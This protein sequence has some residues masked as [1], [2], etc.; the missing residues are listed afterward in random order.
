MRIGRTA[1]DREHYDNLAE[2]YAVINSI[3]Y[4]EKAYI[5]DCVSSKESALPLCTLHF[6]NLEYRCRYTGACSKLLVQFKAS[7][8]L[9]KGSDYADVESFVQKFRVSCPAITVYI[10]KIAAF[11][12]ERAG[13]IRAHSRR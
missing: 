4:L 13:G 6:T 3:E 2:L 10:F 7:F 5:R 12:D 11:S 9:V 1:A 8:K